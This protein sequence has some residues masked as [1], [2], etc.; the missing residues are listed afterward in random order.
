[1]V[2][3][4]ATLAELAKCGQ[5]AGHLAGAAAA[6]V[7]VMEDGNRRFDEGRLAQNLMLAA[8]AHGVGSCIG[9]IFPDDKKRRVRSMLD[10]PSGRWVHT[11]IALGYPADEDALRTS[12]ELRAAKTKVPVPIGRR[13]LDDIVSWERYSRPGADAPGARAR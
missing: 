9:S 7:L 2:R 3:D 5:F 13:S 4:R 11:T 1:V 10:I 8:W 6:L 12:R